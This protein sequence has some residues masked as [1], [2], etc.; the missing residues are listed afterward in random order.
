MGK[1]Y[2][3]F[4]S[5]R[6]PAQSVERSG[7]LKRPIG[8]GIAAWDDS[9]V[10][11]GSF[12]N[13]GSAFTLDTLED[14]IKA[15]RWDLNDETFITGIQFSHSM[16]IDTVI[17]PHLHLVCKNAPG[18][19]PQN[20]RFEFEWDWCDIGDEYGGSTTQDITLDIGGY[21]ALRHFIFEFTDITPAANQGGISSIMIARVK[22]IAAAANPYNTND[23][24]VLGMD[25]HFQKD[26]VG[27]TQ[28]YIK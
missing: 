11:V 23:I 4:N 9:M 12:K 14:T 5:T 15:Y 1:K 26:S 3:N 2:Y 22:R 17:S 25:V 28:E 13:V 19:S 7:L 20:I 24:F 6:Q 18:A 21:P 27:S 10:A 8:E 16:E